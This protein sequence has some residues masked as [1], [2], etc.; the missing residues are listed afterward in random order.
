MANNNEGRGKYE[1]ASFRKQAFNA[2]IGWG[3]STL[4]LWLFNRNH[5]NDSSSS[6]DPSKY[7]DSNVNQI[8]SAVPV[9]LGRV[10]IKN[11]LVSYYGDFDYKPYTEEYGMYSRFPWESIITTLVMGILSLCSKPDKPVFK[12]YD[13]QIPRGVKAAESSRMG[14][15]VLSYDSSSKVAQSY[16]DFAKEVLDYERKE[17]IAKEI[18]KYELLLK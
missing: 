5:D 12:L 7:T 2:F 11:P 15:S 8:G 14:E 9:V 10:M 4:L 3:V 1:I 13:N 6:Q 18:K 16:I 17:K